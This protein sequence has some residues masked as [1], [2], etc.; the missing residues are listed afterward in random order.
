[1]RPS[2]AA[3]PSRRSS[4]LWVYRK[5]FSGIFAVSRQMA[6]IRTQAAHIR[7]KNAGYIA[8]AVDDTY[9]LDAVVRRP[10]EDHDVSRSVRLARRVTLLGVD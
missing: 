3:M 6:S 9:N 5:F 10:I 2:V 7:F 8:C 1:M 4:R